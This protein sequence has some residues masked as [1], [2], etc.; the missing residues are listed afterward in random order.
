METQEPFIINNTSYSGT[1]L[2]SFA[3]ESIRTGKQEPWQTEIYQFI[4]DFFNLIAP[5]KQKTSG[6]TGDPKILDL[7]RESM[8]QSAKMTIRHFN[9][10]RGDKVLLCLPMQ[11]V[12]AKMMLVRAL[13]GG[14]NLITVEPSGD[15]LKNCDTT[16][17]F[18][19]MVPLQLYESLKH[20]ESLGKIEKLLIGGGEINPEL[21]REVRK[22]TTLE[23]FESFA[24]SETYT[25]FALRR[26][27]GDRPESYFKV[28]KKVEI[29]TDH[30]DCL[31]VHI[32]GVTKE[33]V[34]SND[35]VSIKSKSEFEWLGRIDTIIKTGGVKIIPEILE[36][37]IRDIVGHELL[38][39]GIPDEKLGQKL[40]L[41][42]ETAA[43][44]SLIESW[45]KSISS[46]LS[47]PEVPKEIICLVEFPRKS[48]MKVDRF[49]VREM[50]GG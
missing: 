20:P 22:L 25:H 2:I 27:N 17:Q 35:L 47:K 6:T 50:I 7:D 3:Q 10:K 4:V 38:I 36:K 19:A 16:V 24:M 5:L 28:M 30:R 9:L 8:I 13:I 1:A 15:P 34:M 44:Q 43:D 29:S 37:K 11:Y 31:V 14:L 21:L 40:I 26:I 48:S 45:K 49:G 32:P 42:V 18:A 46:I 23:V 33:Q 41:V 39:L 12:A